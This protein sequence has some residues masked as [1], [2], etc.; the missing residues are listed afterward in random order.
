MVARFAR[1]VDDVEQRVHRAQP[2]RVIRRAVRVVR[3]RWNPPQRRVAR[4]DEQR[5]EPRVAYSQAI[6]A[7]E[8]VARPIPSPSDAS[9]T[10]GKMIAA[11]RAK[12]D[13]WRVVLERSTPEDVAT[14]M[15]MVWKGQEDRHGTDD[16]DAPS[17][18]IRRRLT[19]HSTSRSLSSGSSRKA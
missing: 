7:I 6:K 3:A 8:V 4:S 15:E 13:K 19:R 17:R 5:A 2:N 1:Q 10:L 14:M 16:A 9:A 12:P 18:L 11:M